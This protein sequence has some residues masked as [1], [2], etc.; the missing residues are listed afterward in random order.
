MPGTSSD[1]SS[2]FLQNSIQCKLGS[3]RGGG[4][5]VDPL[6]PLNP[7]L[8]TTFSTDNLQKD[9]TYPVTPYRFE[10]SLIMYVLIR[11]DHDVNC[12]QFQTKCILSDVIYSASNSHLLK[13]N[14]F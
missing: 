2:S 11:F 7:P 12:T 13:I 10:L 1:Y 6:P 14:M 8:G 3:E 4:G 9:I 5:A